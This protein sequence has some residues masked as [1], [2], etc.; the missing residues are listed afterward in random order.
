MRISRPAAYLVGIATILPLIAIL[1][2]LGVLLPQLAVRANLYQAAT[3][4]FGRTSSILFGVLVSTALLSL[5]LLAFYLYYLAHTARVPLE[6]KQLWHSLLYFGSVAVMPVFWYFYVRP[7]DP[8]NT[9]NG[10]RQ[11]RSAR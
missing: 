10:K 2:V 9:E 11:D 7:R 6:K 1:V 4:E 3:P 8:N 5:V